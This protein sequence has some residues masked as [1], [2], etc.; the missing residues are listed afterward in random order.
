MHQK[1]QKRNQHDISRP[2]PLRIV[3][4]AVFDPQIGEIRWTRR[5]YAPR[6]FYKRL[7]KLQREIE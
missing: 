7:G 3:I 2:S 1:Q 4:S 6:C 5:I